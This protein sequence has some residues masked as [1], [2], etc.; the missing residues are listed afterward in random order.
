LSEFVGK[1][2]T[3]IISF[4][5]IKMAESNDNKCDSCNK[6][7]SSKY[8]LKSHL[9]RNKKCISLRGI[10]MKSEFVCPACNH[11]SMKKSDLQVHLSLCTEYIMK[12]QKETYENHI[13]ELK[14]IITKIEHQLT[15]QKEEYEEKMEK[16]KLEYQAKL[17]KFENAVIASATDTRKTTTITYNSNNTIHNS[18]TNTLV[19]SKEV[20]EPILRTKLTFSDAIKGQKGLA[21]VVVNNLL[22][23]D[24]GQ[25]LYKCKD[26]SRQNFE[27]TDEQGDVKRDVHASKLI[28]ALIDSKVEKIAGDVGEEAWENDIEKFNAFNEKVSEIVRFARDT[29]AFRSELTALTS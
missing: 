16:Q 11:L 15:L 5:Y 24:N 4:Q 10:E 28:Q 13:L 12:T 29:S 6:I 8:T 22:K 17:E 19:L 3:N 25:L 14:N 1:I 18:N 26:S 20:I 27:Y 23:D 2:P 9:E 7:F 21:N